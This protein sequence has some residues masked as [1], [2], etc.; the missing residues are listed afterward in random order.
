MIFDDLAAD[1]V[2][3]GNGQWT[4]VLLSLQSKHLPVVEVGGFVTSS[5]GCE[6]SHVHL[7]TFCVMFTLLNVQAYYEAEQRQSGRE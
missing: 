7:Q 6:T 5:F 2:V 4:R 1:G 3:S